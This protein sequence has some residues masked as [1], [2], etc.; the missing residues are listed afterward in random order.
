M[1]LLTSSPEQSGFIDRF[2]KRFSKRPDSEHEQAIVRIIITLLFSLFLFIQNVLQKDLPDVTGGFIMLSLMLVFSFAV[3]AWIAIDPSVSIPRRMIGMLADYSA[4]SYLM[5]VYG[6]PMAPLFVLYLW[7][8]TGYG[9]RYGRKY[10]YMAMG[11]SLVGFTAVLEGNSYWITNST[12]GYGLLIGLMVMPIYTAALLGK[13]TRAKAEAEHANKA[14]SQFLANMSHEIRTPMN[15]VIGMIDLL[16]DTPLDE[17]QN[18]FAKTIRTSARNLLLLIDDI[19]D[20]SKIESGKLAIH[21]TNF[22]LHTLLSSTITMLSPQVNDKGLKIQLHVDPN[23]PFLLH[24]DDMHLRQVLINLIGN[25]IKF[26]HDG[27]IDIYVKSVHEDRNNTNIYFEIRDTG[28]GI[29]EQAQETI[30]NDFTQADNTITRKYGGTGLGTTISKQL[31]ELLGGEISLDSEEGVGTTMSFSLPFAKQTYQSSENLLEGKTLVI[32]RD[33]QLVESLK[34]W[35][36]G[37]GLQAS[38]QQDILDT[39]DVD[40]ILSNSQ[41]RI[42]LVDE[43]CLS[44]AIQFATSFS[45]LK[46]STRHGLILLRRKSEPPTQALLEA[47][48]ASVL[49]LPVVQSVMFNALHALYAQMPHV[50]RT[51][52]FS[53]SVKQDIK[54]SSQPGKNIL[55]AEDNHVNQEVISAI[56]KKANHNV[57]IANDGEEALDLLEQREFDI[58]ILDMHMP[59]KSGLE[60]I[61]LHRF[62]GPDNN[63]PFVIL[64]ADISK[65]AVLISKEAGAAEYLTKPVDP[66]RLLQMIDKLTCDKEDSFSNISSLGSIKNSGNVSD[67]LTKPERVVLSRSVLDGIARMDDNPDFLIKLLEDFQE[68]AIVFIRDIEQACTYEDFYSIGESAHAL[69]GGAANLGANAMTDACRKLQETAATDKDKDKCLREC[70]L[71]QASMRQT[72]TAIREYINDVGRKSGT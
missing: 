52:P 8:T 55:V 48:Y 64:S 28:I 20:I 41:H 39:S 24:G 50:D 14:K 1:K 34:A 35:M 45:N 17:E 38:F 69:M 42:I 4:T 65:D 56:L 6:E 54:P 72:R 70:R 10:L 16:L 68:D 31:V 11:M 46:V 22:D 18:H 15:G 5:F 62:M 19:L 32:S 37:W 61:K 13:L 71:L 57:T 43:H 53:L 27:G 49:N 40:G 63:I 3:I 51:V 26:T 47:G 67:L 66:S 2:L 30:F 9:L 33:P 23:T 29:S 12:V 25:A 7:I 59:G 44:D 60:V 21:K 36:N 58:A